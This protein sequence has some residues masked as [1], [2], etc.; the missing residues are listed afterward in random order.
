MAR[1]LAM[2]IIMILDLRNAHIMMEHLSY[3]L[4]LDMSYYLFLDMSISNISKAMF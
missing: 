1:I 4:F 2:T 3:Y